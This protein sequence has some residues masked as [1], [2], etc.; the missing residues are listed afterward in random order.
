MSG[1]SW[2]A[3]R[4]RSGVRRRRVVRSTDDD[5]D[6]LAPTPIAGHLIVCGDEPLA[7]RIIEELVRRYRRQ[8]TVILRSRR[9]NHGPEIARLP[10]VR[11][12]ESERL[13]AEAFR[14]ARVA[15]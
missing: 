1:D 11:I 15:T 9:R 13:D 8:V 5:G 12:V 10:G 6:D 14:L 2:F 4:L 7:H 3:H